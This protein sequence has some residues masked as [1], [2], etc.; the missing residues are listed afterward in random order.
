MF[1]YGKETPSPAESAQRGLQITPTLTWINHIDL[2][3]YLYI[4]IYIHI[5][6]YSFFIVHADVNTRKC[7]RWQEVIVHHCVTL[8][9]GI[10]STASFF[11]VVSEIRPCAY[12]APSLIH[13][14]LPL[15][16][17]T[18]IGQR[19]SRMSSP[20]MFYESIE[21]K[22]HYVH[23]VSSTLLYSEALWVTD[24]NHGTVYLTLFLFSGPR[25]LSL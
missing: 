17:L 2:S 18:T 12:S 22:C 11:C 16:R 13:Y 21:S 8:W 1:Y 25:C 5:Y 6:I 19:S 7:W 24:K 9:S 10:I 20:C 23:G 3:N 4:Y 14:L 15:A